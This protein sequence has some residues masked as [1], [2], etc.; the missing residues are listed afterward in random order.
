MGPGSIGPGNAG[1][2]LSAPAQSVD[3]LF[4]RDHDTKWRRAM[5]ILRVD[6]LLLS[7]VAGHA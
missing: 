2:R 6:P 5:A 3:L 4:D 1:K 7:G